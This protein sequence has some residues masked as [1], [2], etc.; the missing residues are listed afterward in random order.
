MLCWGRFGSIGRDSL[1]VGVRVSWAMWQVGTVTWRWESDELILPL[2]IFP[3][4]QAAHLN[5]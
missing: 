2:L 1:F 4:R 3:G 5:W